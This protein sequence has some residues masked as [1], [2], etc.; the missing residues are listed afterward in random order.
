MKRLVMMLILI[1][2]LLVSC[3]ISKPVLP[4]WDVTLNIPLISR[5]FFVSDLV[6][7]VNI[8]TDDNDILTI[9]GSGSMESPPFGLVRLSTNISANN[10]P[11]VSGINADIAVPLFDS[12]GKTDVSYGEI[13]TGVLKTMFSDMAP[14]VTLIELS[15]EEFR[16]PNGDTF[17]VSYQGESGW[18]EHS[19][20]SLKIGSMDSGVIVDSLHLSVRIFSSLPDKVPVGNLSLGITEPICFRVFQGHLRERTVWLDEESTFIDI[21]YPFGI[22]DAIRL[23]E[24]SLK[25]YITNELGFHCTFHG[26]VLAENNRTGEKLSMPILDENDNP[27]TINPGTMTGPSFTELIFED[28][29]S[30]L[31][32]IMPDKISLQDAYFTLCCGT[33]EEV[34]SVRETDMISLRYQADAPFIFEL[35]ESTVAPDKPMELKLTDEQRDLIR[36]YANDA[37]LGLMIK[38]KIPLGFTANLY[39]GDTDTIDHEDS[40]TYLIHKSLTLRSNKWVDENPGHPDLTQ[41]GYQLFNL[42]LSRAE[43]ELFSDANLHLLWT[44][45]FDNSGIIT[46]TASPA[47]YIHIKSMMRLNVRIKEDMW[48]DF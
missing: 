12:A 37:H 38:N 8:I 30:Q 32:Q 7:S 40:S 10:I 29:I 27:Y 1:A 23:Q 4:E 6:D 26:S 17:S 19:L 42:S 14:E 22:E 48:D 9:T 20:A 13:A 43:M 24:A 28:N 2:G 45:N 47:D 18:Q 25:I 44:F 5:S 34:G 11:L 31:M 33:E 35:T 46:V 15:I 36:T 16:F 21:D 41:D 3:N 39:F